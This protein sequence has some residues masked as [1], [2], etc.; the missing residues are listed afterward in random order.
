MARRK[1]RK[2][3]QRK[4]SK[5]INAL[6][7]A[8]GYMLANVVTETMFRT[9]PVTF[10]TGYANG[11]FNFSDDF[12][13]SNT[14]TLPEII[15]GPTVSKS[16]Q[17][18]GATTTGQLIKYNLERNNSAAK[19]VFGVVGIPIAFRVG[20]QVMRKPR[21]QLNSLLKMTGLGVRV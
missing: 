1:G 14:L 18:Y 20:K 19:L 5:T 15:Q 13:G 2:K 16:F 12:G 4:R 7:L 11:K 8:E 6:N 17:Q 21:S 10:L 9:N 3:T